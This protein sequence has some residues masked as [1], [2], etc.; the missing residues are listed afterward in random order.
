MEKIAAKKFNYDHQSSYKCRGRLG[1]STNRNVRAQRASENR[2]LS[3]MDEVSKRRRMPLSPLVD[4]NVSDTTNSEM[5]TKTAENQR[6]NH[7]QPQL[8]RREKLLKWREERKQKKQSEPQKKSFVV[9]QVKH[10]KDANLFATASKNPANG[11][12]PLMKPAQFAPNKSA[13]PVTRSSARLAKQ[14][15]PPSGDDNKS[16]PVKKVDPKSKVTQPVKG[17]VKSEKTGIVT[18]RGSRSRPPSVSNT[19]Q[20]GTEPKSQVKTRSQAKKVKA[21]GSKEPCLTKRD[22]NDREKEQMSSVENTKR[23]EGKQLPDI[24]SLKNTVSFGRGSTEAVERVQSEATSANETSSFAPADFKFTAPTGVNTFTY[25]SK[26]FTFQPLSPNSAAE[27]MFP[28]SVSSLFSLSPK[29][30]E[31]KQVQDESLEDAVAAYNKSIIAI[32][33]TDEDNTNNVEKKSLSTPGECLMEAPDKAG[34]PQNTSEVAEESIGSSN[35]DR[36]GIEINDTKPPSTACDILMEEPHD[37]ERQKSVAEVVND[38]NSTEMLETLMQPVAVNCADVESMES[39]PADQ[40]EHDSTHFRN[41]LKQETDRLNDTC[42]KW[43]KISNEEE[44]LHDEV[45][46]Q[47]R[48]TIGQAHLLIDQRFR[49]FS[50]LIDLSED[51]NAEKQA[52]ASDLQGFWEMIYYQVEDVNA[53]FDALEKLKENN[54]QEEEK[55]TRKITRK[56]KPKKEAAVASTKGRSKVARTRSRIQEM[57]MAMKAKMA[58]DKEKLTAEKRHQEEDAFITIL[59]PVKMSKKN[60]D[61]NDVVL[62]PVRRSTRRTP[63]KPSILK[64]TPVVVTTPKIINQDSPGLRLTPDNADKPNEMAIS[65][66]AMESERTHELAALDETCAEKPLGEKDTFGTEVDPKIEE[67]KMEINPPVIL[68]SA[69]KSTRSR[70]QMFSV[71]FQSPTEIEDQQRTPESTDQEEGN[72][73]VNSASVSNPLETEVPRRKKGTPQRFLSRRCRRRVSTPY[74]HDKPRRRC[75]TGDSDTA[76]SE[77]QSSGDSD[78]SDAKERGPVSELR[79][80]QRKTP[81]K[82]RDSTPLG[83]KREQEGQS[84]AVSVK[85]FHVTEGSAGSD[86]FKNDSEQDSFAKFLCP[87]SS[88]EEERAKELSELENVCDENG[89]KKNDCSVNDEEFPAPLEQTQDAI[90]PVLP[91][92][93]SKTARTP[94]HL[95]KYISDVDTPSPNSRQIT[96]MP[97]TTIFVSPPDCSENPA[98]ADSVAMTSPEEFVR[99]F[100]A[101]T[102]S[103]GLGTPSVKLASLNLDSPENEEKRR[104]SVF[105]A[106]KSSFSES[107]VKENLMCFSPVMERDDDDE[108]MD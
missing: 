60:D 38:E 74:Y 10:E 20:V 59:T 77:T 4:E 97:K 100:P 5:E 26:T 72:V 98:L 99:P 36:Q 43:D 12:I 25:L 54:W 52:T 57:K 45:T 62:T 70:S 31:V 61:S 53:K 44:N 80:S 49:Q 88:D 79:R 67:D 42:K 29:K 22:K 47:I 104:D 69:C 83:E 13:K 78:S 35:I 71:T 94:I 58:A 24:G 106:P 7:P 93:A 105:F 28:S 21:E 85:L 95:L 87:S 75:A 37:A 1:A 50:G 55:K 34:K 3:R 73:P 101:R 66:N 40:H 46:G 82:Y 84:P 19:N 39:D 32:S 18:R 16:H 6:G 41:L 96:P 91:D 48:T 2:H 108:E 92:S 90:E 63:S 30:P 86:S 107:L 89:T 27:F 23:S 56:T 14:V 33:S 51:K 64:G 11:M 81:S 15:S 8:S 76:E 102:E 9:R 68:K 65:G 103:E 17:E